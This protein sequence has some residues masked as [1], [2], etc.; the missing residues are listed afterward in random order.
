MPLKPGQYPLRAAAVR[1]AVALG[2]VLLVVA[3]SA[4]G[5]A[6]VDN[7]SE[8][9]LLTIAVMAAAW[10]GGP[11]PALAA[12]LAGVL[13]SSR[14]SATT[15]T[16]A[17]D[18]HLALFIIHGL[19]VT[20][21]IAEMTR[22]RR[23]A[24]ARMRE[25]QEARRAGE[26]V[27]RLKDE[28]LA[29]VSHELRTP[30]NAML[31]WVHLLRSG[32][33][34]EATR[35]RGL[36]S[37]E[38]N[39]RHQAKLTGELLDLSR[40]LTGTLCVE[41]R[42]VSLTDAAA[43]AMRAALPAAQAKNV[44]IAASFADEPVM[45]LGDATRLRQVAWSLLANA[46]KFTTS[47]GRVEIDVRAQRGRAVLTVSDTGVGIEQE[48]LPRIFDRFAQEDASPTRAAGG[49]GI[50]LSIAHDLVELHGGD[51]SAGNRAPTGA[52]F[53]VRLPL[54]DVRTGASP[55]R[56]PAGPATLLGV[57]VLLL[58]RDVDEREALQLVLEQRGAEVRAV[59]S[60][61]DALEQLESWRPDVLLADGPG[62]SDTVAVCVKVRRF[63]PEHGGRIPAL[64][65][66]QYARTDGRVR[67]LLE[68]STR[69]LPRPVEPAAL[70]AEIERMTA[71]SRRAAS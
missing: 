51:I 1:Y 30:L 58:D 33:L 43:E 65:L 7:G 18:F 55:E 44:E 56:T 35:A 13:A 19:L 11:G 61:A 9:L 53:V 22:S 39:A 60:L 34:D 8:F 57:R 28:F 48:F 47:G 59:A 46:I 41:S 40:A 71:W 67:S 66:T 10:L 69:D 62:S 27:H 42:L 2:L 3:L 29:T 4:A 38:R 63:D 17:A 64:A 6:A 52:T 36:A 45:V 37:I 68:G 12:V 49:L 15:P 32:V 21:V 16:T 14:E 26:Q 50:G 31:G 23:T 24:E 20:A 5:G 25:A 70:T 54:Q